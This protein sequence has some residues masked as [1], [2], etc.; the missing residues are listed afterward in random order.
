MSTLQYLFKKKNI[1]VDF[2]LEIETVSEFS[3]GRELENRKK[4]EFLY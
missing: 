4:C 3:I 1:W 2:E